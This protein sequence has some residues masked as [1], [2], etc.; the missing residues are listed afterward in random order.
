LSNQQLKAK[1]IEDAPVGF[2][3]D[4]PVTKG[5]GRFGPFH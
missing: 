5:K 4:K 1:R 3:E 2:Y